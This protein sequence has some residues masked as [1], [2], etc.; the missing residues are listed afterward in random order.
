MG[1]RRSPSEPKTQVGSFPAGVSPK[2]MACRKLHH[3]VTEVRIDGHRLGWPRGE[4]C[5]V[6][7]PAFRCSAPDPRPLPEAVQRPWP[8]P[9]DTVRGDIADNDCAI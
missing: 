2:V 9:L 8:A 6:R 5:R 4:P 3:N 7:D 1:R